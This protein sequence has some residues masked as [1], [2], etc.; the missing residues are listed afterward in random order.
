MGI[1]KLDDA[2]EVFILHLR[3]KGNVLMISSATSFRELETAVKNIPGKVPVILCV[4]GKGVLN[5]KI[6]RTNQTD[7]AWERG[8]DFTTL[9]YTKTDSGQQS[10][11][12]FA[13]R[14]QFDKT[15]EKLLSYKLDIIDFYIGPFA[16]ALFKKVS[17][18]NALVSG[19]WQLEFL[20]GSLSAFSREDKCDSKT[21][22][23]GHQLSSW[24]ILLYG[25]GI[26]F[27]TGRPGISGSM[28]K[29]VQP[30]EAIYKR[31]F[32]RIGVAFLVTMFLTL[33]S[34][35]LL[36]WKYSS[37]N[38]ALNQENI[39]SGQT[40][41]NIVNLEKQKGIKM[42]MMEDAGH[43]SK[44]FLSFYSSTL[45]NSIPH[46]IQIDEM[47]IVP[48]Q[49]DIK[50]NK[51]VLLNASHILLKGVASDEKALN[52]WIKTTE[53]VQWLKKLEIITLK[54]DKNDIQHFEL[55]LLL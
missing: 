47:E 36:T 40:Y 13:R 9:Y 7:L 17:G 20:N 45:I 32:N 28:P 25:A 14:S 27:F 51:K 38:A 43:L 4:D 54:K 35:Y 23:D 31:A 8:L 19:D 39:F 48:V 21:E 15:V 18:E 12:S 50:E 22:I 53:N 42:K 11:I 24:H 16:G 30:T 10:F 46:Q 6:D 5:K 2:E 26:S 29:E 52:S 3:K 1:R 34:S 41:K 55:K 49:S 37:E 44:N 33:F